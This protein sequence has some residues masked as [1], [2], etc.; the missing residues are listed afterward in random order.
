[1][2]KRERVAAAPSGPAAGVLECEQV[3]VLRGGVRALSGVGLRVAAGE[4]VGLIG[5]NGAGKTT[6]LDVLSGFLAPTEG[7][8]RVD[9]HEVGDL[10]ASR[11]ARLGVHRTFQ[12]S[13]LFSGLSV[14]ENVL[15]GAVSMGASRAEARRQCDQLLTALELQ[16]VRHQR[17]RGLPQGIT[18]RIVLA[19]A[20]STRPRFLLLDEPAAGLS[21]VETEEFEGL[22]RM[23]QR[24]GAAVLVVEH[25]MRFVESV[26][27]RIYV[28]TEGELLFEG[29]VEE[30]FANA[31]VQAAYLGEA[32]MASSEGEALP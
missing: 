6:L 20:L 25:D 14:E 7:K 21:E 18:Q 2:R 26:C 30:T 32:E 29:T 4:V 8:V 24:E 23:A 31:Q 15:I 17:C 12:G 22:L 27:D 11:R 3:S 13:R 16:G 5:P 9:G 19:R 28:L 1:M 10:V